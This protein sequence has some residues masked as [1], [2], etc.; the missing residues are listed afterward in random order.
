MGLVRLSCDCQREN[1]VTAISRLGW[2]HLRDSSRRD[3]GD[4]RAN[5]DRRRREKRK[6]TRDKNYFFV[7]G[8]VPAIR[9]RSIIL[10]AHLAET[11][12]NYMSFV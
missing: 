6:M 8:T 2:V 4:S 12:K 3:R 9:A 5:R 1:H 7:V 11:A 10:I